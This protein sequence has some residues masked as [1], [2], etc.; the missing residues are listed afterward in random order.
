MSGQF[1]VGV[2]GVGHMGSYH[3]AALSELLDYEIVAV[4]DLNENRA[5]SIA[6][7][8]GTV[9]FKKP[10]EMID[11][12]DAVTIA[13]PTR[14]HFSVSRLF[15]E[16][17]VHVLVEKPICNTLEESKEL[18]EIAKKNKLVLHI[19]HVERFN[20]AVQELKNIV[21]NPSLIECRRMGPFTER[22]RDDGVVLDLMIHD[23]DIVL[24]LMNEKIVSLS[25]V[26][27]TVQSQ[28]DDIANVQIVFE[29]RCV[30]N[31][32]ASRVTQSKIRT[33]SISQ[34][35]AYITL[36]YGD[37][38]LRIQRK[39]SSEHQLS[40]ED[41]KYREQSELERL[42]VHKDNPLKLELRH[43]LDSALAKKVVE[44]PNLDL[45]SLEVALQIL[46]ILDIPTPVSS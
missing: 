23:L 38:E 36:D 45:W 2:V 42:F 40:R 31:L 19:G 12:V 13:V 14:H 34:P 11:S 43:F 8:Y 27:S 30:S 33:L 9:F 29:N 44:N 26:G 32:I 4:C 25:A 3:V 1:R 35:D 15:L 41:L 24:R 37:Q 6:D 18:F 39:A 7:K 46:E 21:S 10:E 22:V 20:G 5:K 17:G 16:N 28:R